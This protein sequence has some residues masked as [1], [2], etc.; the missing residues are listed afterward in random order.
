MIYTFQVP[1]LVALF[2]M[3][4][5]LAKPAVSFLLFTSENNNQF[6]D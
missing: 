1:Y 2:P 4:L 5:F 6:V 3:F